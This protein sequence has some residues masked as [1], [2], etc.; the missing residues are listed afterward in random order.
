MSLEQRSN[1]YSAD[2]LRVSPEIAIQRFKQIIKLIYKKH[3]LPLPNRNQVYMADSAVEAEYGLSRVY[4]SSDIDILTPEPKD[5]SPK[6]ISQLENEIRNALGES[7][8]DFNFAPLEDLQSGNAYG[9]MCR[10][11][12]NFSWN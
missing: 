1:R 8:V 12:S 7:G 10:R 3:R 2:R 9:R 11:I 6:K 5:I 4:N